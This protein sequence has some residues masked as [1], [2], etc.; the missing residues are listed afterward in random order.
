MDEFAAWYLKSLG[1]RHI[2]SGTSLMI[3]NPSA[4]MWAINVNENVDSLPEVFLSEG[5]AR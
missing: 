5:Q 2:Q 4:R 3:A 1:G